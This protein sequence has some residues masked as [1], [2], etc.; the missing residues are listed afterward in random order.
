M[1][2]ELKS[3]MLRYLDT[4]EEATRSGADLASGEMADVAGQFV[5]YQLWLSV[6][7]A[8][9]FLVVMLLAARGANYA[10]AN[11]ANLDPK[12]PDGFV[13][14]AY[15]VAF[16]VGCVGLAGFV[17]NA[18][19]VAKALVAPKVMVLEEVARLIGQAT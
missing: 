1:E 2:D 11:A 9:P 16:V 7:W 4:L 15:C 6:L 3:R 14:F 17:Y 5:A 10:K 12:D 8:M 13:A 19:G 18:N